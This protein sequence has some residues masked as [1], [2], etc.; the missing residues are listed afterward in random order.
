[1][2][3]LIHWKGRGKMWYVV[4]TVLC[5]KHCVHGLDAVVDAGEADRSLRCTMHGCTYR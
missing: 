5:N 1:M 3:M 4:N 2:G